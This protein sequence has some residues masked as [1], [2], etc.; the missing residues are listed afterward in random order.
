MATD[1]SVKVGTNKNLTLPTLTEENQAPLGSSRNPIRIIQQGNQ[2]TS[3]QH[4][5][6]DQLSQ[7]M[8][9]K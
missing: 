8:Q 2:Y 9:V 3:L 5:T 6:Q 4:L 7:I 1:N